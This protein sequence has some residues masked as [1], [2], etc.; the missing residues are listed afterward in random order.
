MTARRFH[1]DRTQW[2]G[3]FVPRKPRHPIAKL[4][5]GLLALGILAAM[6]VLGLF[7]GVAMLL[8]GMLYKLWRMRGRPIAPH[9]HGW[10]RAD[11]RVLA[12]QVWGQGR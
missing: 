3:A 8:A 7:V 1:F 10:L 6:I 2:R 4:S 11:Y 9:S 5:I 12:K